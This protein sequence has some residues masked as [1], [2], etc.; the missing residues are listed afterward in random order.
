MKLMISVVSLAE[1]KMAL[2]G[3]AEIL[4]VKNPS[5]GALG[6]QSPGVIRG[7]VD[8]ASNKASVSAAIGDMPNLP[9]TAALATLGAATCGV[10]YI[11]VGLHGP[12]SETEAVTLLQEMRHAIEDFRTSII[13][14]AYADFRRAGTL[15]PLYLP[16]IAASAGVKGCLLDTFVKDGLCLLEFLNPQQL[17]TLVEES[18]AAG[19][20]FGIAGTLQE[21]DI[22]LIQDLG[23]DIVGFRAAACRNNQRS[24]PL[25]IARVQK[26]RSLLRKGSR[27]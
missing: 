8:L 15:N 16:R 13:A 6:A 25:E 17:Q 9:G 19:L 11:K 22:P 24:G 3:G 2:Q 27:Q 21:E 1:A 10:D 14:A 5:E 23:A 12:R 4:D 26:L 20:L 18:H 7:I